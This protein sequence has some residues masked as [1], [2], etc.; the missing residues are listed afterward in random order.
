M[1]TSVELDC[2]GKKLQANATKSVVH[3][4]QRVS[5]WQAQ[6]GKNLKQCNYGSVSKCPNKYTET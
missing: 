6:K 5:W 3:K 4:L 2:M 1:Q